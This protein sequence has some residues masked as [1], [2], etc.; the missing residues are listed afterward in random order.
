MAE[1]M[2]TYDNPNGTWGLNNGYDIMEAPAELREALCRLHDYEKTGLSPESVMAIGR[3]YNE[4]VRR[5]DAVVK[6]MGV[7]NLINP[8]DVLLKP[9]NIVKFFNFATELL[10][11]TEEKS[12]ADRKDGGYDKF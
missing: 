2:L 5:C 10:S 1:G 9:G 3:M 8:S 7:T 11:D 4:G 6:T 12:G